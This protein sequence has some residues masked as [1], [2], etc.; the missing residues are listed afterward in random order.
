[1][2]CIGLDGNYNLHGNCMDLRVKAKECA[3][4]RGPAALPPL[5]NIMCTTKRL[6]LKF[7]FMLGINLVQKVLSF[8]LAQ[9]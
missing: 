1:M 8:V 5:K 7:L 4:Q 3:H 9:V 6:S 2:L